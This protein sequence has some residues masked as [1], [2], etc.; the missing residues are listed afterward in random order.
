MIKQQREHEKEKEEMI[1]EVASRVVVSVD[2]TD[3]VKNIK[4]AFKGFAKQ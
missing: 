4:Q 3:A 2:V 1:S